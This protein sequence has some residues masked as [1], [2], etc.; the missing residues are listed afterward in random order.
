[1][2]DGEGRDCM[3]KS[4]NKGFTL[5]EL[6]IVVAVIAVLASVLAPQYLRYVERSRESSDL[7]VATN[8]VRA[9]TVAIADPQNNIP[10]GHYVEVLWITGDESG[11]HAA[12][13][14]I[15]VR[16]GNGSRISVYNESG[17]AFGL[18]ALPSDYDLLPFATDLIGVLGGED[19]RIQYG[20][21]HIADV[22]DG[23]SLLA[24]EGN[25]AFHINTTTGEVALAKLRNI[26]NNAEIVNK[27][28]DLGLPAVPA[29]E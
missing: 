17:G 10:S 12:T 7:Q 1:M 11:A 5:V 26:S 25:L 13:G 24:N 27:W 20:N 3:I 23:K 4:K 8:I 21:E 28:V 29:P 19:Q 14:Q 18:S 2:H 15:M 16:P 22:E 9:A 6:I